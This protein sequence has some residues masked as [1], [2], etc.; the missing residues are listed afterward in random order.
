LEVKVRS[1]PGQSASQ[2]LLLLLALPLALRP[3]IVHAQT[4]DKQVKITEGISVTY[5]T[6]WTPTSAQYENGVELVTPAGVD[7]EK[8]NAILTVHTEHCGDHAAALERL[9][10]IAAEVGTPLPEVISSGGWPAIE[11]RRLAP[12]PQYGD[13]KH[14]SPRSI[15]IWTTTA[16]AVD[17]VLVRAEGVVLQTSD[18]KLADETQ[19]MARTMV[20]AKRA[21]ATAL[22]KDIQ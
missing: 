18:T 2:T 3:G 7:R 4:A 11:R 17:D 13:E 9:A 21:D 5:P 8:L 20:H 10:Q 16:V 19:A 15:A 14:F 1:L 12:A 22:D 6:T